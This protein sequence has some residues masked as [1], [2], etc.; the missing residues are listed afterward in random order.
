M[1]RNGRFLSRLTAWI[2]TL[3]AVSAVSLFATVS[4]LGARTLSRAAAAASS[5]AAKVTVINVGYPQA[6]TGPLAPYGTSYFAGTKLGIKVVNARSTRNGF[7]LNL[8]VRNDQAD[9]KQAATDATEFC[10]DS[11]VRIVTG[12]SDSST[13]AASMPIFSRC[14]LPVL[15]TG[16]SNSQFSKNGGPYFHRDLISDA[17]TGVVLAQFAVNTLKATKIAVFNGTDDYASGIANIFI[18]EAKSLGASIVYQNQYPLGTTDFQ[19]A[20][21]AAQNA[22]PDLVFIAGFIA[23]P[24]KLMQQARQLGM[25]TPFLLTQASHSQQLITLSGGAA[26]GAILPTEFF[27]GVKTPVVQSFV[28]LFRKQYGRVPDVYAAQGYDAIL[29]IEN[30]LR[31]SKGNYSRSSINQAL[32]RSKITGVQGPISFDAHG[33]KIVSAHSLLWVKIVNGQFVLY[34]R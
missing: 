12:V 2:V 27:P 24:T 32:G 26:E 7:R 30:T 19:A 28:S 4:S 14:G 29:T 17:K 20:V 23:E 25:T 9:P 33:D 3:G 10:G 21:T 5:S 34:R 13:M 6:L 11:S 31:L 16:S 1:S 18:G 22:G 8:V 15:S